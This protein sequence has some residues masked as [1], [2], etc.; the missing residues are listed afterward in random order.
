[1]TNVESSLLNLSFPDGTIKVVHIESQEVLLRFVDW[2]E[3]TCELRFGKVAFFQ[4]RKFGSPISEMRVTT[5]REIVLATVMS[6]DLGYDAENFSTELPHAYQIDI[7]E[8]EVVF[9]LV[10]QELTVIISE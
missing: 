6:L 8:D 7:V 4:V 2:R 3:R 9:T 1:M 10:F 5:E